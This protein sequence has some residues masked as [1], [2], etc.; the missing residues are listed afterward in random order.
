VAR[1]RTR[2]KITQTAGAAG[3]TAA[4]AVSDAKDKV[5]P[6]VGEAKD[7]FGPVLDDAKDVIASGLEEAKELLA[8]V[9]A[10]MVETSKKQGRKAAAKA[11]LVEEP[12]KT[13]K[14]RNLLIVL[15]VGSLVAFVYKK[16]ARRSSGP[17]WT[18]SQDVAPT[19]PLPS[20]ETVESPVPTTPDAPLEEHA[21]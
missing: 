6:F 9:A 16:V 5:G 17:Q 7:R 1:T 8:P 12:K 13:H 15:G 21:L 3:S 19:A 11:G 20:E 18:A 2:D 10:E 4:A 14:V